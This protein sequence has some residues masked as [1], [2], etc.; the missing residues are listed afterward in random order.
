MLWAFLA[1][2]LIFQIAFCFLFAAID[3][4]WWPFGPRYHVV[5]GG[6]EDVQQTACQHSK[7]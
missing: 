6:R 1:L 5:E 2:W 3:G 4:A 7:A